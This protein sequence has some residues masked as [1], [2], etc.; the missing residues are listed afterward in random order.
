MK[1]VSTDFDSVKNL[2]AAAAMVAWLGVQLAALAVCAM[3]FPLWARSPVATEQL[4]MIVMLA[5]QTAAAALLF[6][7]LLRNIR[8]AL[9]AIAVAWPMGELASFLADSSASRFVMGEIYVSIWCLTLHLWT[10]ALRRSSEKIFG[11]AIAAMVTFGGPVLF[12]LRI[13]FGETNGSAPP[14]G[15]FGPAAGVVS[16]MIPG[17]RNTITW[18]MLGFFCAL[19]VIAGLAGKKFSRG[20]RQVVH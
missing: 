16:L 2:P 20:S 8:S 15:A 1:Q 10:M 4:A 14:L 18:G 7:V 5:T 9:I 17:E 11:A 3:R 6:P 12:Y 13:E 19:A